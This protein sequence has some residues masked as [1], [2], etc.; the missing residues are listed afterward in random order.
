[1][2]IKNS[3]IVIFIIIFITILALIFYFKSFQ[4]IKNSPLISNQE[5]N[6]V[7]KSYPSQSKIF[8][9]RALKLSLQL[10]KNWNVEEKLTFI[11]LVS[12]NGKINVSRIATNFNNL[13]GYLK[14]FDNKRG[15]KVSTEESLKIS[16]YDSIKRVEIFKGGSISSQKVYFIYIDGW[17]YSLSTS[18]ESL[19]NDLD[20]I[21]KSFKY[22]P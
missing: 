5:R 2:K 3:K 15:L 12:A 13:S 14:D 7:N 21:A 19:Y 22:T 20:Q 16:G 17:I 1:M 6:F 8:Q 10:P 18:S 11:D 9:S 4:F